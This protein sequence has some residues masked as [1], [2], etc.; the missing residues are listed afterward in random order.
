MS[1]EEV[2]EKQRAWASSALGLFR[3][4]LSLMSLVSTYE[5]WAPSERECLAH[6]LCACARSSESVLLLVA[7]GQLWD[8][9]MIIRSVYEGSLKFCYLLQ[10]QESFRGRLSEFS[11]DLFSIGLLK[12]H[13]KAKELLDKVPDPSDPRWAPIRGMLLDHGA[14]AEIRSKYD[15]RRRRALETKW[16]FGGIVSELANSGDAVFLAMPGILFNYSISSHIHHVSSVGASLPF[17]RESRPVERAESVVLAHAARLISDV[18]SFLYIRLMIG[19]RF[20]GQGLP[21]IQECLNQVGQLAHGE[22]RRAYE[23][24]ISVEYG[25]L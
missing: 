5:K 12:D 16:G 15:R 8:A 6:I 18:F 17:E 23:E 22:L 11:E 9:E 19:Y 25:P 3:E 1:S 13:R 20:V 7:Y 14:V 24:W 10:S 2:Y 21:P 4:H